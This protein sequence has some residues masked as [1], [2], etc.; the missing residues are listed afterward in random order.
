MSQ[1]PLT[2]QDIIEKTHLRDVRLINLNANVEMLTPSDLDVN[3]E[4]GEVNVAR[5]GNDMFVR[6]EHKATFVD[7]NGEQAAQVELAHVARFSSDVDL[8]LNDDAVGGWVFG[9]VYFMIYPYVRESLQN[10][11]LRVGLP[12]VVLGY[13]KRDELAPRSITLV[14]NSTTYRREAPA[15]EPFPLGDTQDG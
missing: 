10:V 15:D 4:V 1:A 6:F 9:N 8:E 5:D 2:A 7:G 14:V 11:C 12:A 3:F 13:L